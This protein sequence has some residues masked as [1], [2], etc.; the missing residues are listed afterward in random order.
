M[1]DRVEVA[2]TNKE[3]AGEGDHTELDGEQDG[4]HY[5]VGL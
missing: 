5:L 4:E 1:F 2:A 3:D